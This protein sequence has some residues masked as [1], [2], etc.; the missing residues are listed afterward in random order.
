[1]RTAI[2]SYRDLQLLYYCS[3]IAHFLLTG[4]IG[5]AMNWHR[6]AM[7]DDWFV[8]RLQSSNLAPPPQPEGTQHPLNHHQ[9]VTLFGAQMLEPLLRYVVT[10]SREGLY[11]VVDSPKLRALFLLVNKHR[12]L[13]KWQKSR[14][15]MEAEERRQR[16]EEEEHEGDRSM[17]ANVSVPARPALSRAPSHV[18]LVLVQNDF[19]VRALQILI[20]PHMPRVAAILTP[21]AVAEERAQTDPAMRSSPSNAELDGDDLSNLSVDAHVPRA[22]WASA[23]M[24]CL[25]T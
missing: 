12:W 5:A 14:R 20:R 2:E 4:G 3:C 22:E 24:F 21:E 10:P 16:E 15:H 23:T 1:M 8:R 13:R 6:L 19:M 17:N 18:T 7:K 11:R 9:R 25:R